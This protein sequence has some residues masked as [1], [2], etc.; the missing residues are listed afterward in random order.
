MLVTAEYVRETTFVCHVYQ[1]TAH[2]DSSHMTEHFLNSINALSFERGRVAE[3][4]PD[5]ISTKCHRIEYRLKFQ[6]SLRQGKVGTA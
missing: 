3:E 4:N 2:T 6:I 5:H 1:S